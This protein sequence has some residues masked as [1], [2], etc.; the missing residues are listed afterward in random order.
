MSKKLFGNDDIFINRMKM[1]PELDFYIYNSEVYIN[2]EPNI[3]GSF[4][5]TYKNVPP[6]N[7]SL[8][9]LNINRK[10]EMIYPFVLSGSVN[11]RFGGSVL[12]GN[13]GTQPIGSE[14]YH[15]S[16]Y[17]LS[18]SIYRSTSSAS[19]YRDTLGNTINRNLTGSVLYNI[20]RSKYSVMS[21]RFADSSLTASTLNIVS[22]PSIFYG[23]S[24]KKGSI[25]LK[26]FISGTLI[27]SAVDD[28]QNGEL[29]QNFGLH[30]GSVAGLIYYDEGV[31]VFPQGAAAP[32]DKFTSDYFT[33]TDLD[34]GN[35]IVYDG[36]S[37]AASASWFYFGAGANDG[38]THHAT[39]ASASFSINFKGTSY[40]NTLT[41]MC[42]AD[43][44]EMNW[45]NNPTFLNLTSS[46]YNTYTSGS[47]QYHELESPIKNIVS[48]SYAGH[49]ASF[50]KTT[51]ITK[52][53]IY[54]EHDNL[55]MTAEL[56][57]PYRK[58][59]EKDITFKL[60]YDLI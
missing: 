46:L 50:A 11:E 22:I 40:K 5:N 13:F 54:D 34:S 27:A 58:D 30:S 42:H 39:A 33:A 51:Y 25:T 19:S 53:G 59:E 57:R 10:D 15:T 56:A 17:P 7:I 28:R 38:I 35:N 1:H 29:I 26:Y 6:G 60:K 47:R 3:S 2:N 14:L 9:E 36:T 18:S 43:K 8:Y 21:K 48:S 23:S 52:V 37:T 4:A 45:S 49:S 55:I 24:I 16:S 44:G 32:D 12:H 31:M 41:M 20:G